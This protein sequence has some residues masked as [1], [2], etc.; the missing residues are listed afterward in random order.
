ML[1]NLHQWIENY[2]YVAVALGCFFEGESALLIG[3]LAA[4]E[5]ILTFGGVLL[6]GLIGGFAGDNFWFYMGRHLGQPFIAR[7]PR[8]QKRAAYAKHHLDRYGVWFI[9]GL[10]F[11]YGLRSVTPFVIGAANVSR[12]KYT[13]CDALGCLLWICVMALILMALGSALESALAALNSGRG[14]LTLTAAGVV[15]FAGI[16]LLIFWRT[17]IARQVEAEEG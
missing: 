11:F 2:G 3:T 12:L 17:R 5:R 14:A 9:I 15:L 6:A 10:R 7:R 1:D 8:W 13:L 4:H 16:C